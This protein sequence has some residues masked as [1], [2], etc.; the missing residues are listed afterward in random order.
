M[1]HKTER[2]LDELY[3]GLRA[4]IDQLAGGKI[5][6]EQLLIIYPNPTGLDPI[7][8]RV[9]VRSV[10]SFIEGTAYGLKQ[11][12]IRQSEEL[13]FGERTLANDESYEL[14]DNGEVVRRSARL[15]FL[16]N[17]RFAFKIFAKATEVQFSL[18]TASVGWHHLTIALKIR[19]RLT[20]PK[21]VSDLA[22][23]DDEIRTAFSA[24]T[25]FDSQIILL[26]VHTVKKNR[27]IL[28]EIQSRLD[29]SHMS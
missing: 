8:R 22:V 14:K 6:P 2:T 17:I 27:A 12:A 7:M 24:F 13:S 3:A 25:W 11:F 29:S 5:D 9:L 19:D 4:E 20:H 15:R 10:F 16:S 21:C 18:D 26:L 1:S 28:E 23:T